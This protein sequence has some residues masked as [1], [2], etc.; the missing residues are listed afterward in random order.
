MRRTIC[1]KMSRASLKGARKSKRIDNTEQASTLASMMPT[2]RPVICVAPPALVTVRVCEARINQTP[3]RP[4]DAATYTTQTH[5]QRRS[6]A[7]RPQLLSLVVAAALHQ[8]ASIDGRVCDHVKRVELMLATSSRPLAR[9][10]IW[11]RQ[12]TVMACA[13]CWDAFEWREQRSTKKD[14]FAPCERRHHFRLGRGVGN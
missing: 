9:G 11:R 4:G 10:S 2:W 7:H 12:A 14:G 6:S 3:H 1:F 5:E 8:D 13:M